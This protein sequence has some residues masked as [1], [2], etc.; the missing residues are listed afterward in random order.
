MW[1][2]GEL[3]AS[4]SL[5]R[6]QRQ[7]SRRLLILS[8]RTVFTLFIWNKRSMSISPGVEAIRVLYLITE[9]SN[10]E[11]ASNMLLITTSRLHQGGP[12]LSRATIT[13]GYSD[14][15]SIG[16][17]SWCR[18]DT[19]RFDVREHISGRGF[20]RRLGDFAGSSLDGIPL[21]IAVTANH[22][23][24]ESLMSTQVDVFAFRLVLYEIMTGGSR[25]DGLS[26]QEVALGI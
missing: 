20:G 6:R 17:H 26:D 24:P 11:Y 18:C 7:S 10:P 12:H 25:Y 15:G 21:P 5:T 16:F 2:D 23:F 9:P 22:E 19:R 3:L 8:M 14:G 4:S 13:L 1:L